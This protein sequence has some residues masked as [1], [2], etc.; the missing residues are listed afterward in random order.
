MLIP[1]L[2][3]LSSAPIESV[4]ILVHA[5]VTSHVDY[6]N[7]V[8]SSAPKN[9]MDKIQHVQYAAAR[10]VTGTGKYERVLSW[11]MRDDLRWLVIP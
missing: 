4:F 9:V 5:F 11:M 2:S 6:C 10:L 7:C 8:L 3:F 1:V